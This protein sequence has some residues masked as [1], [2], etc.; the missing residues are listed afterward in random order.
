MAKKTKEELQAELNKRAMKIWK[1]LM[2]QGALDTQEERDSSELSG[3]EPIVLGGQS[4]E[5]KD[6]LWV[7]A[8]NM[9]KKNDPSL[10]NQLDD[11]IGGS[12]VENEAKAKATAFSAFRQSIPTS[13]NQAMKGG[14]VV[15]EDLS[16]LQ[17]IY[18]EENGKIVRGKAATAAIVA[19]ARKDKNLPAEGSENESFTFPNP[20]TGKIEVHQWDGTQ[21]KPVMVDQTNVTLDSRR[22]YDKQGRNLAADQGWTGEQD[23]YQLSGVGDQNTNWGY[24]PPQLP[25]MPKMGQP[26]MPKQPIS[27]GVPEGGVPKGAFTLPTGGDTPPSA[28]EQDPSALAAGEKQGWNINSDTGRVYKTHPYEDSWRNTRYGSG[29]TVNTG[30]GN[31]GYSGTGNVTQV[32]PYD[33]G[34]MFDQEAG[35]NYITPQGYADM[36]SQANYQGISPTFREPFRKYVRR[37]ELDY[38]LMNPQMAADQGSGGF[39][40]YISGRPELSSGAD[41]WEQVQNLL[42]GYRDLDKETQA[43]IGTRFG[44][45]AVGGQKLQRELVNEL[46]GYDVNPLLRDSY[47]QLM[48]AQYARD[49]LQ[50][51]MYRDNPLAYALQQRTGYIAPQ[52]QETGY[53]KA[54]QFDSNGNVWGGSGSGFAQ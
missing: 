13:D 46:Q 2:A 1:D 3:D 32:G 43:Q 23:L 50:N 19:K 49:S 52:L 28:P 40:S 48:N 44:I 41:M 11:L 45:G 51:Q 29:S 22:V 15:T 54:L 33:E 35:V 36:L 47:N 24:N 27:Q 20:L 17:D 42:G 10:V 5:A 12:R 38:G 8:Y 18:F 30:I 39:A 31:A 16:Q 26:N 25:G 7:M 9:A 21:F 34:G 14:H 6:R 53:D 4:Q 37:A